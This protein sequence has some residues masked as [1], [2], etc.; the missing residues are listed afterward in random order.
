MLPAPRVYMNSE[1]R[2]YS[3]DPL[4]LATLRR[5]MLVYLH[6]ITIKMQ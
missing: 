4:S 2:I 3:L 5:T 6:I 1:G